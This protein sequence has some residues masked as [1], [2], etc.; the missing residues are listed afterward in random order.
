MLDYH[1]HI[2]HEVKHLKEGALEIWLTMKNWNLHTIFNYQKEHI[3]WNYEKLHN[4][5]SPLL[6]LNQNTFINSFGGCYK[7]NQIFGESIDH[8]KYHT[9]G[10]LNT[11]QYLFW[12]DAKSFLMYEIINCDK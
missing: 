5:I 2:L 10:C 11:S 6:N 12:F 9:I 3:I 1:V 4:N 7:T 8:K